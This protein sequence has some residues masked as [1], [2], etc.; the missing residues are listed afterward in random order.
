MLFRST[1]VFQTDESIYV[2]NNDDY[3]VT[4]TVVDVI[5]TNLESGITALVRVANVS[6]KGR[7]VAFQAGDEITSANAEGTIGVV[8]RVDV[9]ELRPFT[10][11]VLYIDQ[12]EAVTRHPNQSEE[13]KL[14]F[15]FD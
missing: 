11:S 7:S 6:D 4:G 5:T 12:R 13:I 14:V 9:P 2:S 10:G 3:E 15:R 8:S 1:G